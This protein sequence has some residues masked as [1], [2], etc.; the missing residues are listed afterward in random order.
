MSGYAARSE[1][2]IAMVKEQLQNND[3]ILVKGSHGSN[4]DVVRDAL[5]NVSGTEEVKNTK[6]RE[7]ANA[8]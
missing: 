2:L 3:V 5:L 8:I 6:R 1:G 4:M 7:Q